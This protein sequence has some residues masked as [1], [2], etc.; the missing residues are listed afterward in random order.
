MIGD[1]VT[2]GYCDDMRS[3]NGVTRHIAYFIEKAHSVQLNLLTDVQGL[4]T[5]LPYQILKH[6]SDTCMSVEGVRDYF[7][8]PHSSLFVVEVEIS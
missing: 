6:A 2:I 3:A 7:S 5:E 4:G 1:K 8:S